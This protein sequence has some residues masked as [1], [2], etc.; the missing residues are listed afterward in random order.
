MVRASTPSTNMICAL[1]FIG[2]GSE[3]LPPGTRPL[4]GLIDA[5]PHAYA[6]FRSD[7][8]MSLPRPIGLI[9]DAIADASPPDDPPAVIPLF[10]GL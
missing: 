8:P 2:Y 7:P 3:G 5:I 4:D 9:P 1:R 6:G 10:Q